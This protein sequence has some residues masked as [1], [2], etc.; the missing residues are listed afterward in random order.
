MSVLSACVALLLTATSTN[1]D[2]RAAETAFALGQYEQVKLPLE[3]AL[4]GELSR[5]DRLRGLELKALNA[6]AFDDSRTAIEA[7][8]SILKMNVVYDPGPSVSPKVRGLYAEARKRVPLPAPEPII[9]VQPAPPPLYTRGWFW[10]VT[11]VVV[12]GGITAAYV[13]TRPR[14]PQ[15]NLPTGA[16]R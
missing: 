14:I 8:T 3:R 12:A 7:F 10:A 9:I 13:A 5:A 1:P 11:T 6:T 2:L 4:Q 16:L 15:G